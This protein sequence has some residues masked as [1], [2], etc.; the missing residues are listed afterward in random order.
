MPDLDI[1]FLE[2]P[3]WLSA[4]AKR[5]AVR[6]RVREKYRAK[7]IADLTLARRARDAARDER[8]RVRAEQLAIEQMSKASTGARHHRD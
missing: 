3:H 1:A 8:A 7:H 4:E 6:I 2:G 5:E